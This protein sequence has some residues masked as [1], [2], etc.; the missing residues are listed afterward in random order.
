MRAQNGSASLQERRLILTVTN[1]DLRNPRETEIA[2][3]GAMIRKISGTTLSAS[4]V[5][6]HNTFENPRNVEPKPIGA[7]Q[8][9]NPLP[10]T[11]LPASVTRLDLDLA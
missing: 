10:Y 7:A 2:L 5:H 1:S 11:F 8:V 4:D 6:A 9:A 3:R